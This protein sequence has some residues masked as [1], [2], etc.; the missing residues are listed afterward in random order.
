M[1]GREREVGKSHGLCFRNLVLTRKS[2]GQQPS[3]L[4]SQV[5]SVSDV[6]SAD[7]FFFPL[8]RCLW[9]AVS[10]LVMDNKM[11]HKDIYIFHSFFSFEKVNI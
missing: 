8:S 5:Q 6:T 9:N 2:T 1:E 3:R 10:P 7:G 11:I 4:S